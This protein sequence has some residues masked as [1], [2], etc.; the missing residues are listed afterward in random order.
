MQEK[1]YELF[2]EEQEETTSLNGFN[3]EVKGPNAL[4]K[5]LAKI[6]A[7][8]QVGS[9]YNGVFTG[10]RAGFINGKSTLNCSIDVSVG[11]AIIEVEDIYFLNDE[12]LSMSVPRLTETLALFNFEL[13][14]E[15]AEN[16]VESIAH[17]ISTLAGTTV[18]LTPTLRV[19]GDKQYKNYKIISTQR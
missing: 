2:G 16:G 17:A 7:E 15:D 4:Q 14:D 6:K 18:Q 8:P 9:V 11:N 3:P 13:S 5:A 10:A 19:V 12:A 1:N